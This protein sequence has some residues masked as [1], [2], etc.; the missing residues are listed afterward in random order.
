MNDDY[1]EPIIYDDGFDYGMGVSKSHAVKCI[2]CKWEGTIRDTKGRY[3]NSSPR[4]WR[5]LAGRE[6][7][8]YDCPK[9]GFTVYHDHWKVS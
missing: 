1:E 4:D 9:C 8:E 2:V 7:Y 5:M 3:V 6:G